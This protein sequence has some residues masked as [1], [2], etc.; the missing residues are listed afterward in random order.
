MNN[1]LIIGNNEYIRK[2]EIE[3]LKKE[4]LSP[5]EEDLNYSVHMPDDIGA[6]MDAAQTHSLFGD[7]RVVVIKEVERIEEKAF[8]T[9]FNYIE[10]SLETT[11]LIMVSAASFKKSKKYKRLFQLVKVISATTVFTTCG[12]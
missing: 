7:K 3:K 4:Y 11:V 6:V 2:T 10:K 8:E 5:D 9:L 1:Y 12:H